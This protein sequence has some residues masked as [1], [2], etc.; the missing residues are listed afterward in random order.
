[1]GPGDWG[2]KSP[3]PDGLH[4]LRQ[5]REEFMIVSEQYDERIKEPDMYSLR[6]ILRFEK[7]VCIYIILVSISL[8]GGRETRYGGRGEVG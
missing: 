7:I 2:F 3:Y 8:L 5:N 4:I 1:M 6:I